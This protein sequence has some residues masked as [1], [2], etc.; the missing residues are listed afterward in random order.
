M[1]DC[2]AFTI[3]SINF[4]Y[5]GNPTGSCWAGAERGSCDGPGAAAAVRAQCLGRRFCAV[6]RRVHVY[7]LRR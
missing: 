7:L 1:V 5:F 2:G 4:A 6:V 3:A